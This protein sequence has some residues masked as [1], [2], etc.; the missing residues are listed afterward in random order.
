MPISQN[1]LKEQT[2]VCEKVATFKTSKGEHKEVYTLKLSDGQPAFEVWESQY[3]KASKG[4]VFRPVLSVIPTAY[5]NKDGK[6]YANMKPVIN[7][8]KVQEVK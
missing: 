5:T 3:F 7:W 2:A 6:A 4:E 8:E 1:A